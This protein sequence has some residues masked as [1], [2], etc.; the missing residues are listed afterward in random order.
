[1]SAGS[2]PFKERAP[3]VYSITPFTD[4]FNEGAVG[5]NT[6]ATRGPG[7]IMILSDITS[8]G[9]KLPFVVI[10]ETTASLMI[11]LFPTTGFCVFFVTL[12]AG[13]K[14]TRLTSVD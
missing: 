2:P 4:K 1:M 10:G 5:T 3:L 8:F 7:A 6:G 12:C 13:T 9:T 14:G 11:L